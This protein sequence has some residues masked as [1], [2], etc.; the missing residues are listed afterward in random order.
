[1]ENEINI[2]A[3]AGLILLIT[4]TVTRLYPEWNKMNVT[5]VAT[6][7]VGSLGY[8]LSDSIGFITVLMAL[9]TEVTAYNIVTKSVMKLWNTYP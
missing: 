3:M 7:L 5:L 9:A 1:M 8:F 4:Q 6:L 2:G